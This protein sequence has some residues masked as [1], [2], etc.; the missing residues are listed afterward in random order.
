MKFISE[1][2]FRFVM[3][4]GKKSEFSL[5]E[6]MFVFQLRLAGDSLKNIERKCLELNG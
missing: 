2:P 5:C 6:R 4:A 1:Y 3:R